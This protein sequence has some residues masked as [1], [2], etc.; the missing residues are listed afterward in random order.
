MVVQGARARAA[1][2]QP[3]W[4]CRAARHR[5]ARRAFQA[6]P[7]R[8]RHACARLARM[9]GR[10]VPQDHRRRSEGAAAAARQLRRHDRGGDLRA[11]AMPTLVLTGAEDHDNGSAEALADALP[12]RANIV[13]VPG[14]HMSA[15]DQARTGPGDRG[16]SRPLTG[17]KR[18]VHERA[19]T[20]PETEDAAM[21]TSVS[22]LAIAVAACLAAGCATDRRRADAA[23]ARPQPTPPPAPNA[24]AAAAD[25][26]RGRRLRRPGR[27]RAGRILRDQQPRRNGSTRPTSPRIPTRSP[28]ISARS[29]PRW[30]SAS[31]TRRRAMQNVAGPQPRHAAQARHPAPRPDPAG[32]DHARAPRPSSTGSPPTSPRNMAAAAARWAARR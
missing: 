14:N 11:I 1:D 28:P 26:R 20:R 23:A 13:E 2:R 19:A 29:A 7:E 25:R 3:A 21:K 30:G 17:L 15:V 9:D 27:A 12:E 22:L 6:D 10:G 32:A 8:A 4:G 16:L 5:R 24:A 31:P 18:R